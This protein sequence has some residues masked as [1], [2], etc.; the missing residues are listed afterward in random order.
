MTNLSRFSLALAAAVLFASCGSRDTDKDK[1]ITN[2]TTTTVQDTGKLDELTEFKYDMVISNIPIPFDILITLNKSGVNYNRSILNDPSN[3]SKYAQNDS[4][5]VNLGIYGG[6]IAYVITFE[7]FSEVGGF[8]KSAK[9]LA[10]DLGIP[11]AFDQRALS[12]YDKYKNNKDSLERIV[13]NSYSAVDKTLKSNERIGLAS[14]VVTGGWIEGL[15]TS[16]RTLNNAPKSD[17]NKAIYDKI[18]NQKV[19]LEKLVGLLQEFS[20]GDQFYAGLI[21]D[22]NSLK[23]VYDGFPSKTELSQADVEAIGKKI[24]EIRNKYANG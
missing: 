15:Y 6:D 5:A 16:T 7:Q 18:L 4:K 11:I 19:H 20:A 9:K 21:T 13:F 2:D 12:N 17:K 1:T 3:L 8:L 10:D 24:D 14:L 22:L 23:A